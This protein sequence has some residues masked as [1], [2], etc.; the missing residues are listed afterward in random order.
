MDKFTFIGNADVNAIDHL[1][2]QYR[3]NPESVDAEWLKFFEGI[4]FASTNFESNGEIPE[5]FQKEFKVINL[6]NGY[7]SRGHLFTK[8]NPVRDRRTYTP[9][10]DIENFGLAESDLDEVFQAGNEIGVGAATLRV[11]IGHME[12]VYCQSIGI[13]FNYI[14]EP[15]R[16]SWLKHNIEI[17]NR[18]KFDKE[19]KHRILQKLTEA[20]NFESFLQKKYVGQKRFS[21]EGGEAFIPGLDALMCKGASLGVEEF[22]V[23]MAHRGRLNTLANIFNK[24]PR[25][26]FSEFDGKQFDMDDSFDGDVKYHQGYSASTVDKAGNTFHLTLAPNPSHLEAVDPVVQ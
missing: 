3:S 1:Y 20:S 9:T 11:I 19:R 2:K 12:A 14:R 8:T 4:D 13:E 6:I 17:E 22:V 26:I 18:P 25:D 16:W 23:G 24:Q 5:N 21:V 15:E 10:L 7:R